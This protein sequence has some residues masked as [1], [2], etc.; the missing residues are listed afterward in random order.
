VKSDA[1]PPGRDG[2]GQ[3]R[4]AGSSRYVLVTTGDCQSIRN[5]SPKIL[6]P[7]STPAVSSIEPVPTRPRIGGRARTAT[8][9]SPSAGATRTTRERRPGSQWRTMARGSRCRRRTR[10]RRHPFASGTG[11]RAEDDEGEGR[12]EQRQDDAAWTRDACV[13]LAVYPARRR[14]PRPA[15]SQPA[16]CLIN[17]L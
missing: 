5:L 3:D 15:I 17:R 10:S 1:L 8:L 12:G 13:A 6:A 14:P 2:R 9:P 11:P 16:I 4:D 7:G